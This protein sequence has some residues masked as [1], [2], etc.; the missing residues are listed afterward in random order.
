MKRITPKIKKLDLV[1]S[2]INLLYIAVAITLVIYLFTVMYVPERSQWERNPINY[3]YELIFG[4]NLVQTT[5]NIIISLLVGFLIV[6]IP[7][8]FKSFQRYLD[9]KTIEVDEWSYRHQ[10]L[11]SAF[12]IATLNPFSASVRIY[13]GR[14]VQLYVAE[15]GMKQGFINSGKSIK[16]GLISTYQVIKSTSIKF[17]KFIRILTKQIIQIILNIF[18][19]IIFVFKWILIRLKVIALALIYLFVSKGSEKYEKYLKTKEKDKKALIAYREK[20]KQERIDQ[21]IALDALIES[22]KDKTRTQ[23]ELDEITRKDVVMKIVRMVL[24]YGTLSFTALFIFIPFYWM[25]ITALKTYAESSMSSN[26]SFFVS[27]SDMQWVNF[28]IA[29]TEFNFLRYIG[30]TVFVGLTSMF[31]TVI[32]TVLAAFAFSRLDFKGKD[33]IFSLLLMTMMI[34]GELYTIT[35]Y[36]TVSRLGWI[37]TFYALIVPFS[38]SVFYIFF[39]R[40]TFRQI[41]DSLYRAAKVDGCSDFKYLTRVMIPIA[42][43]TIITIIILSSIGAWDAYIWPQLVGRTEATRLVSVALR[44]ENFSI[45]VGA[46][47][48]PMYNLQLAATTVVTVP[49]LIVF[50]SLKKYILAG[51]GRSGTKG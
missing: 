44:N 14:H 34:P 51:V 39:L 30:N 12:E 20:R 26:P 36:I 43:P 9:K 46:D 5:M 21:K 16:V 13:L 10:Y 33:F 7:M 24:T 27:L 49:L 48:R 8:T 19:A 42:S 28:K 29:L 32:T 40:Q 25:I 1:A 11:L 17:W 15:Y 37:D 2:L 4:I 35:N 47:Q 41:P 18:N 23:D 38:A 31:F 22:G 50:F 45:G 3:E 6:T